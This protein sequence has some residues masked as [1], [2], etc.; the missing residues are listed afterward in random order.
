MDKKIIAGIIV[1]IIILFGGLIYLGFQQK[2][3]LEPSLDE[4]EPKTEAE[5]QPGEISPGEIPPGLPAN[6]V[7]GTIK[8]VSKDSFTL[9][10]KEEGI[11]EIKIGPETEIFVGAT[12]EIGSIIDIKEGLVAICQ[13]SEQ[14]DVAIKIN[15]I[16]PETKFK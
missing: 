7:F 13:M 11:K 5:I 10:I 3:S 14:G 12:G 6:F 8:E 4:A 2:I 9:D 1:I 15:I 16:L